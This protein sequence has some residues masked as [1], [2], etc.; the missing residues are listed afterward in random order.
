MV[1][2]SGDSTKFKPIFPYF[3]CPK[4]SYN[5][6]LDLLFFKFALISQGTANSFNILQIYNCVI[7]RPK[8][9]YDIRIYLF[10]ITPEE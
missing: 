4:I 2:Y 6:P 10:N 9:L 1:P 5:F 7:K 8:K 3:K